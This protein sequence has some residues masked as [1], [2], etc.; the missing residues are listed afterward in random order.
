[1]NLKP[2]HDN[3]VIRVN[4]ETQS[5]GGIVIP[6][7]AAE[8]PSQGTVLAVGPGARKDD[9]DLVPVSVKTGDVVVFKQY[10]GTTIKVE[11]EEVLVVRDADI[12]ALVE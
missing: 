3:I 4:E 7:N 1:M 10:A 5:A 11:G 6:T 8:K 9:G 2:L 12:V